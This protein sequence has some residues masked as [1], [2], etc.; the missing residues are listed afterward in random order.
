MFPKPR[1][2][3]GGTLTDITAVTGTA[4]LAAPASWRKELRDCELTV[5][6]SW[7]ERQGS[8]RKLYLMALRKGCISKNV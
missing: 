1:A 5:A 2:W 7:P 3:N 6:R 4:M 8:G